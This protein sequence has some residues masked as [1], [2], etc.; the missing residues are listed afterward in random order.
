MHD[1]DPPD[2]QEGEEPGAAT[3]PTPGDAPDDDGAA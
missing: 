2:K 3:H 1:P